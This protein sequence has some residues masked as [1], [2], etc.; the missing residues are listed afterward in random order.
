MKTAK[1][2]EAA[3]RAN[4]TELLANHKAEL[5]ITDD[6]SGYGFQQGVAEITMMSEYDTDGN[7][8]AEFTEFRI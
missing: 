3:F 8:T 6:G 1:E 5:N 2:R 4:L 7:Q